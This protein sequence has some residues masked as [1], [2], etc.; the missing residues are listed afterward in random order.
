[1]MLGK[2]VIKRGI[3][4]ASAL[5]LLVAVMTSPIRP[6]IHALSHT[7]PNCLRRNYAIPPSHSTRHSVVSIA[8]R[9]ITV[10]AVRSEEEERKLG[11]MTSPAWCSFDVP[12]VPAIETSTQD[13]ATFG[14]MPT[15]QL[16]RC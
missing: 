8:L 4:I 9:V 7:R 13:T 15:A 2:N 16:L 10:K 12:P 1:M 6:S 11:R 14:F 3:C 5:S